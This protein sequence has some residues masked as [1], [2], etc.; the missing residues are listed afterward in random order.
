[1]TRP[2]PGT[3]AALLPDDWAVID[4]ED[5]DRLAAV[6]SLVDQQLSGSPELTR[7][8]TAIR[9][10]LLTSTERA[11]RAGGVLMAL[12]VGAGGAPAVP[13]SLT[14]Y[15]VPG[16]LDARGRAAM[17]DVLATDE[18]GHTLDIGEGPAGTVLRRVRPGSASTELTGDHT[19]PALVAD[20]WVEPAPGVQLVYLVFSSPLV[21]LRDQLVE[22]FDT[23]VASV[24]VLDPSHPGATRATTEEDT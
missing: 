11:A 18:P 16:S 14:V 12:A 10:E 17:T 24:R 15:R 1:M 7:L 19:L 5:D 3:V 13:A 8:R 21:D 4:L 2:T 20:Y 23:V 22:L 6:E 9:H